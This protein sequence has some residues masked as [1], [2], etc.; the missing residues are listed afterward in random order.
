MSAHTSS[1][2][3]EIRTRGRTGDLIYREQAGE[4]VCSWEFETGDSLAA[5]FLPDVLPAWAAANLS[6]IMHSIAEHVL[7]TQAPLHTAVIDEKDRSITI[8]RPRVPKP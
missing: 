5:I 7:R 1:A 3:V 2:N 8:K 4:L 6:S